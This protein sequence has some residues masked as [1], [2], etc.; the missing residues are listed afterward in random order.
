MAFGLSQPVSISSP[1]EKR[2]AEAVLLHHA[3][4][5]ERQLRD[6]MLQ[7]LDGDAEA[8]RSLLHGLVPV[9]T[10]FFSEKTDA[11]SNDLEEL[12]QETLIAVHLRRHTYCPERS[13]LRWIYAIA[14]HKASIRREN[15]SRIFYEAIRT[16]VLRALKR[17]TRHAMRAFSEADRISNGGWG[18]LAVMYTEGRPNRAFTARMGRVDCEIGG[19]L[20]QEPHGPASS[21]RFDIKNAGLPSASSSDCRA[22]DCGTVSDRGVCDARSG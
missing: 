14:A 5:K 12:L 8:Y 17:F 2:E 16:I 15:R 9:I 18:G 3:D 10:A 11:A 21:A 22:D 4:E 7:A 20:E 13:L 1:F 19:I 6:L